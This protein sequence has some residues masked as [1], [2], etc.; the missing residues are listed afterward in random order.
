MKFTLTYDGSLPPSGNK[1]NKQ[2]KWDIRK[3]LHPQL[4][5]LWTNHP[6]M[7]AVYENRHFPK[8]GGAPLLQTHHQIGGPVIGAVR[9]LH[10]GPTP[11]PPVEL[12]D[13][14]KPINKH[15]RLFRP[16][17]R[18]S[19]ALHCGLK[20]LFLRKEPPGAI[21]QAMTYQGGDIDGR[22]RTVLDALAMP[23][24]VE[25]MVDDQDAPDPMHC[26]LEDDSLISGLGVE[27][28]RLLTD[29][30]HPRDYARLIIEVDVRVR[31]TTIYN[32]AFLG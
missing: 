2:T 13:L 1:A 30:S 3:Q 27:G 25:Q 6:A 28:E 11:P 17:V 14:C 18:E 21:Y 26:L 12:L 20:I 29:Q 16:L 5:D 15:G 22:I 4:D 7:R 24:H 10:T 9:R 23:Q 8:T 31:Q 32:L 19:Y